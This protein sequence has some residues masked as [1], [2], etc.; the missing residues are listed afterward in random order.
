MY[1]RTKKVVDLFFESVWV[2]LDVRRGRAMAKGG[3]FAYEKGEGHLPKDPAHAP[4]ELRP[5]ALGQ[6]SRNHAPQWWKGHDPARS[7]RL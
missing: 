7:P 4:R 6:R 2:T 3:M 5:Q 1:C